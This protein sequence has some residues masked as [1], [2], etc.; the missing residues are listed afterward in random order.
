MWSPPP[1]PQPRTRS[2]TGPRARALQPSP[3]PPP[4]TARKALPERPYNTIGNLFL[5]TG[6]HA[7]FRTM[8]ARQLEKNGP[9]PDSDLLPLSLTITTPFHGVYF[10]EAA[11]EKTRLIKCH[12]QP[13]RINP[14]EHSFTSNSIP[15][16]VAVYTYPFSSSFRRN[17][18]CS[19]VTTALMYDALC[20]PSRNTRREIRFRSFGILLTRQWRNI[21]YYQRIMA[22]K[23]S[24]HKH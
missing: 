2:G 12:N 19:T 14:N 4:R 3:F 7:R 24:K 13:T 11:T 1:G 6:I 9:R 15:N 5:F 22:N 21:R 10:I 8:L 16:P 20:W 23:N 18:T 17:L